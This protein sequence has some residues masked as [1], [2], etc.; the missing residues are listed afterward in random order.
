MNKNVLVV[1]SVLVVSGCSKK[2]EIKEDEVIIHRAEEVAT[3]VRAGGSVFKAIPVTE[4][5]AIIRGVIVKKY[6]SAELGTTW[7]VGT[8]EANVRVYPTWQYQ[9]IPVGTPI[10]VNCLRWETMNMDLAP[11]RRW[12]EFSNCTKVV[13]EK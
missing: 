10:V 12:A 8:E 4:K 2:E 11:V 13:V 5:S 9:N 1:L 7:Y 6:A 3:T